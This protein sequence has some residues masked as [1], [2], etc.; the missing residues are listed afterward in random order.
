MCILVLKRNVIR[1]CREIRCSV[2]CCDSSVGS[3][4][5]ALSVNDGTP[6]ARRRTCERGALEVCRRRVEGGSC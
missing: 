6:T 4:V 2:N 1:K 5:D 3:P